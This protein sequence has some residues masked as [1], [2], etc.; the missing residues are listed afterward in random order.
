MG[1]HVL[2]ISS[3]WFQLFRLEPMLSFQ[4]M[5]SPLFSFLS[6]VHHPNN[7]PHFDPYTFCQRRCRASSLRIMLIHWLRSLRYHA[8]IKSSSQ[9]LNHDYMPHEQYPPKWRQ[10]SS[11]FMTTPTNIRRYSRRSY[12]GLEATL[13]HAP[14]YP[15]CY[16]PYIMQNYIQIQFPHRIR[17]HLLSPF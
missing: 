17:Y 10:I 1:F 14:R 7:Q 5:F 11:I 4:V 9:Q 3:L 2:W 8:P 6:E 15:H 13:N 12:L 16:G